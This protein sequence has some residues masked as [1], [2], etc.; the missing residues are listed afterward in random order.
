MFKLLIVGESGVGKTCLLLRF[1]D[2]SFE[3][4]HVST[5]GVDFKVK[6][7]EVDDRRVKLQIWDS[8]GQ[9]RFRNITTSYYRN[10]S[11]ILLAYDVTDQTTFEK[12]GGWISEVRKHTSVPVMLIGNKADMEDSR[13]VSAADG[14]R[15]A[16]EQQI[17]FMETSAKDNTNVHDAFVELAKMLLKEKD[18]GQGN[19]GV[20]LNKRAEQ[21][22]KKKFC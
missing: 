17:V 10:T 7:I 2:D 19:N 11:G 13:Q 4:N 22:K 16:D 8:A 1:S 6:E 21:K 5:I 14:K 12:V 18:A 9:E 20:D 15:L 3:S